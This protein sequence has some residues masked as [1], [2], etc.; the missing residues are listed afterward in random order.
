MSEIK[1][2]FQGGKMNKDLD[3][4]IIPNG[5]YR[6]ALNVQIRTSDGD[7]VGTVQNLK[8][9]HKVWNGENK[10]DSSKD[11]Y[12][13]WMGDVTLN[14]NNK[15]SL[16]EVIGS[17][18]DEKNDKIYFFIKAPSFD[19]T[20]K[21][22]TNT[23]Y[24][25]TVMITS[26][27]KFNDCIVE[28]NVKN[29]AESAVVVDNFAIINTFAEISPSHPNIDA[30]NS[31]A[32]FSTVGGTPYT[33]IDVTSANN[34]YRP[35]MTIRAVKSDGTNIFP[36]S[37]VV[38]IKSYKSGTITLY[39]GHTKNIFNSAAND[40]THFIFEHEDRPLNF[41]NNIN[42]INAINIIDNLLFWTD[43]LAE[44]KKINIDR[45]KHGTSGYHN[46]TKL[47][48]KNPGTGLYQNVAGNTIDPGL[49]DYPNSPW[50][51]EE[52]ITV[53]RKAPTYAPTLHMKRV[54]REELTEG[55]F[56]N[57]YGFA[58]NS[59]E[60]YD[61]YPGDL[62]VISNDIFESTLFTLNDILVFTQ[63]DADVE[64]TPAVLKAKFICYED[65][66]GIDTCST[67][68]TASNGGNCAI[69]N[70][71]RVEM[72]AVDPS[73]TQWMGNWI[74]SLE[75]QKPLYELKMGRFGLRYKYEDGEYSSFG[76]WSELAFLPD[77]YD[78]QSKRGYNLGMVNTIR[79][80]VIKDFIPYP[81]P[82]DVVGVDI[83]WKST[84]SPSVYVMSSAERK[85]DSE[86]EEFSTDPTN[87][88]IK[89]GELHVTSEM[90]HKVVPSNQILRS[91]DNVPRYAL[92]QE[93]V[94]NRLLYGNYVQ[95]YDFKYPVSLTQ[96][97]VS[98]DT[99]SLNNPQKSIK[100][101]R[102][103]KFGMVFGDKHGRET[104]VM[105]SG[106]VVSQ[107]DTDNPY[108]AFTGDLSVPKTLSTKKNSIELMQVWGNTINTNYIPHDWIDYIK[109]YVKEPTNEY[110]NLIMDRWYW[111]EDEQRNV[112][113]SFNSA[114]RN[115]VDEETHLILKNKHNSHQAVIDKARY[116]ILAIEN[117]VPEYVKTVQNN[118]GMCLLEPSAN[119]VL[120]AW[121]DS[122]TI[123][124]IIWDQCLINNNLH[125]AC[126][127]PTAGYNTKKV[128][129]GLPMW[130]AST[131][132]VLWNTMDGFM[133]DITHPLGKE[134]KGQL[135]LRIRGKYD[136]RYLYTRWQNVSSWGVIEDLRGMT[137][138]LTDD[139]YCATAGSCVNDG[140]IDAMNECYEM[141]YANQPVPL[142]E[143][144]FSEPFGEEIDMYTRWKNIIGEENLST[145]SPSCCGGNV[146]VPGLEY[147][148]ELREDVQEHKAEYDGKFFVKVEGDGVILSNVVGSTL[149][150]Q[151]YVPTASYPIHYVS[152]ARGGVDSSLNLGEQIGGPFTGYVTDLD[153]GDYWGAFP[154]NED[155]ID[156]SNI[157]T[158]FGGILEAGCPQLFAS[159][160]KTFWESFRDQ[161]S[162][163][164]NGGTNW[165]NIVD[166]TFLDDARMVYGHMPSSDWT[167]ENEGTPEGGGPYTPKSFDVGIE[168]NADGSIGAQGGGMGRMTL[169][170][171]GNEF[172][173]NPKN[174]GELKYDLSEVGT[175]FRWAGDPFG[176]ENI[177]QV[178]AFHDDDSDLV[179][180]DVN[181]Y[182]SNF[183]DESDC[184]VCNT[185]NNGTNFVGACHRRT[186]QVEFRKIQLFSSETTNEGM[187]MSQWDPRS[188]MDQWGQS[189]QV[190]EILQLQSVSTNMVGEVR[191]GAVWETEPKES[192]ELDIYYEA[193]DAIPVNLNENNIYN[194]APIDSKI[195]I[196]RPD[197][198]DAPTSWT[199]I[200]LP[201]TN[202][203][204]SWIS[205]LSKNEA[206][207]Q[208]RTQNQITGTWDDIN[209]ILKGDE[210]RF[211][212]KNGTITKSKITDLAKYAEDSFQPNS[213][214]STFTSTNAFLNIEYST[215]TAL[216]GNDDYLYLYTVAGETRTFT[217]DNGVEQTVPK[218]WITKN[219]TIWG[220]MDSAFNQIS[221]VYNYF[222]G[223]G[224]GSSEVWDGGDT[225]FWN[226]IPD[227]E[228]WNSLPSDTT[229]QITGLLGGD[230][231]AF[232]SEV[233]SAGGLVTELGSGDGSL[234]TFI[235][236]SPNNTLVGPDLVPIDQ[237]YI[238]L[239]G[240]DSIDFP[241]FVQ[242]ELKDYSMFPTH[243]TGEP[244]E[245][246]IDTETGD[247]LEELNPNYNPSYGDYRGILWRLNDLSAVNQYYFIDTEVW[248]YPIRLGWHNCYSFGNGA[249][250]DRIRDDYNAPQIDNGV[251][252][253]TTFSGYSEETKG[254]GMIYSGLYNSTSEVND[255]NEF[256][257]S[258]K[259][260]KNLNPAYGSI[261]ALKTR[262]TDVVVLT[263][264]KVLKVLANK[265]ALYNAD[266]NPQ[267]TATDR[268]LGTAVPFV[269]DYGISKNP[270]SLAWDQFRL[271]FTDKQRG[272]VLRLSRD[273]LTPISNVGMRTWFR[274]N[275]PKAQSLLGTFDTVNG[276]YNLT[277]H[278]YDEVNDKTV[279]FNE[280]AKGWVSF[281]SFIP[282][283]G[284]S[285]SGKYI[286]AHNYELFDHY[287]ESETTYNKFYGTQYESSIKL[288]F[289]DLPG[290]IKSFKAINYEGSQSKVTEHTNVD[291]A[292]GLT[293]ITDSAGNLIDDLADGQYYNLNAKE[294]WYINSFETD[295]QSGSVPEFIN[296]EGKW[297]NKI[298]GIITETS[299]IDTSEFTVQGIGDVTWIYNYVPE[300]YVPD[301][302]IPG[303][304]S[305]TAC[306]YDP[307]ATWEDNSC[308]EPATNAD[309]DGNCLDEFVDLND[310]NGCVATISGCTN[311]QYLEY[312]SE[313]NVDDGSCVTLSQDGCMD[314]TACNYN[315]SATQ[316]PN[317]SCLF[318][319]DCLGICGGSA[320]LDDCEVCEGDNSTCAG[321]DGV[322]YSGLIFDECG[323]CDGDNT[324][325][326]GCDGVINSGLTVD[327]CGECG[328]DG[329]GCLGCDGIIDSGLVEDA[330]GVCGGSGPDVGYDCDGNLIDDGIPDD[331]IWNISNY[332][333]DSSATI[334]GVCEEGQV[335]DD[336]QGICVDD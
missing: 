158:S 205:D 331:Q 210:I 41:S 15:P 134:I 181:G 27:R 262:D 278:G 192:T 188:N 324:S 222:V 212:H 94:G 261:Q 263:E 78:Y 23:S 122:T 6:N 309:C 236:P 281:K 140:G 160:T 113:L 275:L 46:H 227:V 231:V 265:D 258:Q 99:P 175:I 228:I 306:N 264:D 106:Y 234:G 284:K 14:I 142:V 243:T 87:N 279:S 291:N 84:D 139:G 40:I 68:S 76:P 155:G 325:C 285:A 330:C 1:R 235:P 297:F 211:H 97:I 336:A 103:Y 214:D 25:A 127:I 172:T 216:I 138:W 209:N 60:P 86:W 287:R 299:N 173:N 165:N 100:S 259:I 81:R 300:G 62:V 115:K 286:T 109:Y 50:L 190:I 98:D 89:T 34:K 182:G 11:Y 312:N 17:V 38:R 33:R 128:Y 249:E 229:I 244:N 315:S 156:T 196:V 67:E 66:D 268:V 64:D 59:G 56:S 302:S 22:F 301:G 117:D 247:P 58:L 80:L 271:Y 335:W 250:S 16:P 295:L 242:V 178:I 207:V 256:N 129:L 36:S 88:N 161:A 272:A 53:I 305:L 85:K 316:D 49:L 193:S 20:E 47:S 145:V 274:E 198:P 303:C 35:G 91:W 327:V 10:N 203:Y 208:I 326:L 7:D 107:S 204:R 238:D 39:G 28:Y 184:A 245:Y 311:D 257:L 269:G 195:S 334:E 185:A 171:L 108:V 63:T 194:F 321:C 167:D 82:L 219:N 73:L 137:C 223:L 280:G 95:G 83:L 141:G 226:I 217:D 2:T 276:E 189:Y 121:V 248:K 70:R 307:T 191:D 159:Q 13:D 329:T 197:N 132:N 333:D 240:Y 136:N 213:I 54:N 152:S 294:G 48:I 230:G 45:C 114:D 57:F 29:S 266:G 32:D 125:Q 314:E 304:T 260:T 43:N 174:P 72:V 31:L 322:P 151:N 224:V 296:K 169:S 102:D 5:E 317:N 233:S 30:G 163:T 176:E 218:V 131:G 65:W 74:F 237:N 26:E 220:D 71:I 55:Y 267:L 147:Y 104:P 179:G 119:G 135:K 79:E 170:Y 24:D 144:H 298:N 133:G 215:D 77:D 206:A 69:T 199:N 9:T 201:Y 200:S 273:G 4:R 61:L 37:E 150:S 51:K 116:K 289:N 202:L 18:A 96:N 166:V 90:I 277:L 105:T 42:N 3:E 310:G 239:P 111:A 183:I 319:T 313:A 146:N 186:Y 19:D 255:L 8:S 283:T 232:G 153:N 292:T 282:N 118:L 124:T 288:I 130:N 168:A 180:E 320:V 75:L 44:P 328:G 154:S 126:T 149:H 157:N 318:T 120:G 92:A 241:I 123:D 21:I 112:W 251:K 221:D 323:V 225:Y 254:S 246:L 290:S 308:I 101:I 332:T 253:S 293:T 143:L 93:I 12:R 52:H 252:V 162:Q 110:Y 164:H 270:E 148:I 187:V 177:Y